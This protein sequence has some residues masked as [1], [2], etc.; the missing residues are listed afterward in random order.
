MTLWELR[1][2]S[3]VKII[4]NKNKIKKIIISVFLTILILF[5]NSCD[6]FDMYIRKGLDGVNLYELTV[7]GEALG[8]DIKVVEL[9]GFDVNNFRNDRVSYYI[10]MYQGNWKPHMQRII[11]RAQI[12][13]PYIKEVFKE[14]NVPEDLIYLPIIESSFNPQAISRAGAAGLWQFMPMTGAIYN[15]KV[16]YWAD[17]RFDPERSTK[18]AA[19]H[20]IRLN[21][22]FK[23]WVIALAAYNAGGGRIS[24]AIKKAKSNIFDDLIKAE[25]LPKETREYIPKYVAAVII[26][27]NP[28]RFGFKINK[29]NVIFP[30]GDL[31]YIDDAADLSIIAKMI[32]VDTADLKA[33][34]PHLARN[35]TPPAMVR[36]PLRIPEG[37]EQ[38][39]YDTFGKIPPEE[40][41]TFRKHEV[42]MNETLSHLSRF[43]NVPMQAIVE[44]NK[45]KTRNLNIGQQVMIPIQGLDNAKQV[46]MAQYEEERERLRDGRFVYFESLPS[47]DYEYKDIMYHIREGDTLWIIARKFKIDISEIK[48]WNKLKNNVLSVGSEIFL[49]IP[50]NR[51]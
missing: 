43:Y 24:R 25:V 39:F 49:R 5:A 15:L 6:T 1:K 27:K 37:K 31:V 14:K 11:D 17:D 35:V 2:N 44:I 48:A 34:N 12:Y 28:E 26:A 32:E 46:D 16:N 19:E 20:L 8:R 29:P 23:S 40:R 51:D 9:A 21:K 13:L 47:P 7:Y 45:L 30:Q 18:A 38:K 41:I 50:V 33:L 10:S 4:I 42:K 36:Y 3:K 22:N